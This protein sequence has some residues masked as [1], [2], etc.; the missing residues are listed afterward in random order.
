LGFCRPLLVPEEELSASE[1]AL[2]RS[3]QNDR[4]VDALQGMSERAQ[5]RAAIVQQLVAEFDGDTLSDEVLQKIQRQWSRFSITEEDEVRDNQASESS[6]NQLSFIDESYPDEDEEHLA[7][8]M[9]LEFK[10]D[11][12]E[13]EDYDDQVLDLSRDMGIALGEDIFPDSTRGEVELIEPV[14]E[15]EETY[16]DELD[17]ILHGSTNGVDPDF[18]FRDI[19]SACLTLPC[20]KEAHNRHRGPT[21]FNFPHAML[22]GWQDSAVGRLAEHL[23]SHPQV[24]NSGE[25]VSFVFCFFLFKYPARH[26]FFNFFFLPTTFRYLTKLLIPL[27]CITGI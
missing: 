3:D 19:I 21:Q 5:Q 9:A 14:E 15:D 18:T 27:H 1:L 17:T 8:A 13:E 23:S 25:R 12:Y 16:P 22:M 10:L 11:E 20:L 6:T 7:A 2:L 26:N 4:E 24:I